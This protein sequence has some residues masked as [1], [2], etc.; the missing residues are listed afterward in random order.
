PEDA[1]QVFSADKFE[2]FFINA[3][4]E[5]YRLL[6]GELHKQIKIPA[7]VGVIAFFEIVSPG[8][9]KRFVITAV[10][11]SDSGFIPASF[12]PVCAVP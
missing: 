6:A 8:F 4:P 9:E 3:L 1:Q 10:Q 12:S 7:L 5:R 2:I 11:R